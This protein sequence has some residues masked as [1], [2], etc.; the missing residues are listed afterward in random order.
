ML[1]CVLGTKNFTKLGHCIYSP[2]VNN[3]PFSIYC[4]WYQTGEL[5]KACWSSFLEEKKFG[6]EEKVE[7]ITPLKMNPVQTLWILRFVEDVLGSG[8]CSR[9]Q[10]KNGK[11]KIRTG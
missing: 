6:N 8:F 5:L 10:E 11:K 2:F 7:T 4:Y 3:V 1:N 9:L